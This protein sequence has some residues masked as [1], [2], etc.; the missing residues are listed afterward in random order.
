MYTH[1][2]MKI[3]RLYKWTYMS[4]TIDIHQQKKNLYKDEKNV[5]KMYQVFFI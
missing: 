3:N 4:K 5:N 1:N 2:Y